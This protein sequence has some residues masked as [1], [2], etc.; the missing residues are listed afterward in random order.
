MKCWNVS[1]HLMNQREVKQY[2]LRESF[3]LSQRGLYYTKKAIKCFLRLYL[4]FPMGLGHG[5][6]KILNFSLMSSLF[7]CRAYIYSSASEVEEAEAAAASSGCPGFFAAHLYF[8]DP[9]RSEGGFLW[10]GKRWSWVGAPL[11]LYG[12]LVKAAS[13]A[14]MAS[15]AAAAATRRRR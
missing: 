10:N 15:T 11:L 8:G 12:G 7:A 5:S 2:V 13:E 3:L 6:R 14:A 1:T 9:G 4:V